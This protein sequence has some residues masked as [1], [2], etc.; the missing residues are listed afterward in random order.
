MQPDWIDLCRSFDARRVDFL[1]IGGQAV[2]A[3]GYPR[4]TKDMDLWVRPSVENGARVLEALTDFGSPLAEFEPER[5]RDTEAIIMLGREP[6]RVDILTHIPGV[7]FQTAWER[8]GSISL[9]GVVVPLISLQDL[10]ANKKAVGRLQDLAD[11][12]ALE[13]VMTAG[14]RGK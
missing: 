6:F 3:H 5:F 4:L 12:E 9:D 10:I 14:G 13:A 8:R 11:V 7:D 2:I 1:L